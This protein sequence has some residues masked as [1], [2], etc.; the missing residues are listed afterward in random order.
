MIFLFPE[1]IALNF[2]DK[3]YAFCAEHNI[4]TAQFEREAGLSKGMISKW[5]T[6]GF[7]PNYRTQEKI[8]AYMKMTVEDLMRKIPAAVTADLIH[9]GLHS[10][11]IIRDSSIKYIPVLN[12]VIE[13]LHDG[14]GNAGSYLPVLPDSAGY[15]GNCFAML[16]PD[17][18]MM[19]EF[20]TNDILIIQRCSEPAS[21]DI[22][23]VC[24][25]GEMPL[26]RK[27][28]REKDRIILQPFTR[29]CNAV[30]YTIEEMDLIQAAFIGKVI[31]MEREI[32]N[33][34]DSKDE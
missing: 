21:G 5:K 30:S 27:L 12:D 6:K 14:P 20:N 32:H 10:T 4:T 13:E 29:Q 17:S 2:L 7:M 3:I 16:M 26:V 1:V 18:S 24:V 19:P 22:V 28:V 15:A 33:P 23:V 11:D 9:E 8:A 31:R 25:P 34:S